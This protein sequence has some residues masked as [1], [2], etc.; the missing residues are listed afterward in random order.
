MSSSGANIGDSPFIKR[1]GKA[2]IVKFKLVQGKK[3]IEPWK[4]KDANVMEWM[5]NSSA[6]LGDLREELATFWKIEKDSPVYYEDSMKADYKMDMAYFTSEKDGRSFD[7]AARLL[8]KRIK[9]GDRVKLEIL[10]CCSIIDV[11]RFEDEVLT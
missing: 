1:K 10:G 6:M 4:G 5:R 7:V 9:V 3:E 2:P 8:D 11:S